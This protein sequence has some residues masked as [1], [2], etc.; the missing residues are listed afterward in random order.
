[1]PVNARHRKA[2]GVQVHANAAYV[3]AGGDRS[4]YSLEGRV[5][6]PCLVLPHKTV[7]DGIGTEDF[8]GPVTPRSFSGPE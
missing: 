6:M 3:S 5:D 8:V 4:R 7:T 2:P 1:M